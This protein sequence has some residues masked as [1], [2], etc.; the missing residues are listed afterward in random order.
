MSRDSTIYT[1]GTALNRAQDNG[2]PVQVLVEGHWIDG[3]VLAVDGHGVVL[4]C[5]TLGHTV[6]KMDSVSAVRVLS[7]APGRPPLPAGAGR[8]PASS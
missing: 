3:H 4:E 6:V 1:T 8:V 7:E 2:L 5:D